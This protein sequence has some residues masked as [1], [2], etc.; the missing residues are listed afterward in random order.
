M[1]RQ[2]VRRVFSFAASGAPDRAPFIISIVLLFSAFLLVGGARDDLLSLLIWR[3]LSA[4]L[5]MLSIAL[6]SRE[7]WLRGRSVLIFCIAVVA[8]VAL[9][10]WPLPPA[11][12]SSLPGRDIIV[13]TYEAAGM[14]LPWQPI[15]MA[16]A[17]TWNALFSLAGPIAILIATLSL[18]RPRHQQ[19]LIML[20]VIGFV[21]GLL[22][23]IQ[24]IGP[25]NGPLYFY[26]ITNGDVSVGLFANRNHQAMFLATLYPLLAANLSLFKGRPDRLFFH[27]AITLAGAGLLVPLILMTG[28]RAGLLLMVIGV[29]SAWWVYRSPVAKGRIDGIRSEHR[30]RLVG[31][32]VAVLL[33]LVVATVAVRTPALQR[34]LDT[35]PASEQRV[36]AL[37]IIAKAIQ[38]FFPFGS[39]I[40]TFVE[41]YQIFEP[42]SFVAVSYFNHA[43]NDFIEL[44][45]TGGIPAAVLLLWAGWLGISWFVSLQR[46]RVVSYDASEFGAQVLGRAGLAVL[47]MLALASVADYP[48]RTPSLMLFA[49]IMAAW[50]VNARRLAKK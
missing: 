1:K 18:D 45:L 46:S 42:D 35:D 20:I 48:L 27:R 49:M 24:A 19:L 5:L 32:G 34:L 2:N 17:R 8:L 22:G 15:S 7:A 3:P 16:Q 44:I 40:G 28:S 13:N 33:L 29:G 4:F 14:A 6:C 21:S 9:H 50:C 11:I 38:E 37:P 26:R 39:G 23:M 12:W 30:S 31:L 41:T 36:Q 43:H 25:S 47:V 10:L